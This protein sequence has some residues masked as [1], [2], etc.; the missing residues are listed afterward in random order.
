MGKA[1]FAPLQ[2]RVKLYVSLHLDYL[3]LV[4]DSGTFNIS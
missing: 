3:W 1:F 2:D 4:G